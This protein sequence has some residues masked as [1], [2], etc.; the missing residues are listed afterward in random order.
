MWDYVESASHEALIIT[1][2]SICDAGKLW[3]GLST[4]ETFNHNL[5]DFPVHH[6]PLSIHYP[7]LHVL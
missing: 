3:I 6:G 2:T 4:F 1:I 5:V 7:A